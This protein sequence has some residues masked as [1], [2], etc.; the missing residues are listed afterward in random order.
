MCLMD[1][2]TV[3]AFG[4]VSRPPCFCCT[5]F[6]VQLRAHVEKL[7]NDACTDCL[8]I[9]VLA[10]AILHSQQVQVSILQYG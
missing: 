9:V 5:V 10:D 4:H 8:D 7:R 2:I 1:L 6:C 3:F